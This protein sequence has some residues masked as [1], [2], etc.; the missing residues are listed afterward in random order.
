MAPTAAPEMPAPEGEPMGM[1]DG[2]L[3]TLPVADDMFDEP[4]NGGYDDG[5]AG[6][7][8]V[9]FAGGG[10]P[11][12]RMTDEEY[13]RY[14]LHRESR[15][16]GDYDKD[17]KPLTSRAGAKYA[18]QVL[19]ATARS[20]GYGVTPAKADTPEEYNRVGR[21]Y[22]L[23]LR[24]KYGD[25]GGLAA[26]NMGPGAYEA[27][28]AGKLRMPGETRNYI[29]GVA[30]GAAPR[31]PAQA[32]AAAPEAAGEE[33][34]A[35][36]MPS[37]LGQADQFRGALSANM[38]PATKRREE[39]IAEL[40][41]SLSPE[42]RKQERKSRMWEALAQF[43][44]EMAQTPGGLLQAASSAASK[45]LP[46]LRK[47]DADAKAQLRA[48][49]SAL[50]ALED[51]SN[52][53]KREIEALALELAKAEAGLLLDKDKMSLQYK[54]AKMDDVTQ[55]AIAAAS[56]HAQLWATSFSGRLGAAT[57]ERDRAAQIQIA[58]IREGRSSNAEDTRNRV[59]AGKGGGEGA[60][61]G[62]KYLGTE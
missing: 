32:A 5:Y 55:R 6:G 35:S 60:S 3:A 61:T 54:I 39:M 29:S 13:L 20:P 12:K 49:R 8:I 50:V 43:G 22:A 10:S 4:T 38:S 59:A 18:M 31:G 11:S 40:E 57:S 21:E 26:Y 42:A 17:G 62:Y 28:K 52:E 53:E 27:Y 2:G 47:G 1:A 23:A 15:G 33:D 14:I 41:G 51:K 30:G 46:T 24:A 9:A 56:R 34:F 25:E 7:G 19:D 58:G 16:R 44:F 36:K 45:T 37:I 48:D